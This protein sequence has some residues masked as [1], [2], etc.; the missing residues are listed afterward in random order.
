MRASLGSLRSLLVPPVVRGTRVER[1]D[2]PRQQ[3][4]WRDGEVLVEAM[5]S[6]LS[7]S[8]R[9]DRDMDEQLDFCDEGQRGRR[10]NKAMPQ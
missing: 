3:N 5:D 6:S 1:V 8:C 2:P 10:V 7:D 4:S 9:G